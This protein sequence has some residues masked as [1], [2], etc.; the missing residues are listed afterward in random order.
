[1]DWES[2]SSSSEPRRCQPELSRKLIAV[3]EEF[4]EPVF[5]GYKLGSF[6]SQSMRKF[7][8]STDHINSNLQF[9]SRNRTI[10]N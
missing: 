7:H 2:S 3:T 8:G 4:R 10:F 1:V 6:L 9:F 5:F